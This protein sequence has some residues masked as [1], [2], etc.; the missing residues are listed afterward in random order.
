[1]SVWSLVDPQPCCSGYA[2]VRE[3][4]CNKTFIQPRQRSTIRE[5]RAG[6]IRM[7][8]SANFLAT[9]SL[10]PAAQRWMQELPVTSRRQSELIRRLQQVLRRLRISQL[11]SLC[12]LRQRSET[13]GQA[14]QLPRTRKIS[15]GC[16]GRRLVGQR[17][18]RCRAI[19][20][21]D[22]AI[23]LA[24]FERLFERAVL[25]QQLRR[26]LRSDTLGTRQLVRGV[27]AQVMKSGTC[28]GS[29]P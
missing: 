3:A 26:T 16:P 25:A 23:K 4:Q 5:T 12:R 17:G 20:R 13:L 8:R 21:R 2:V 10:L 14:V 24:S 29:T 9:P 28:R 11:R 19:H 15:G 27:P 7:L 1:M 22:P 6:V 18:Q